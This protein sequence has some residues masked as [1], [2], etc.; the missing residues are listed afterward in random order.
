[1]ASAA[2]AEIALE[3]FGVH[4]TVSLDDPSLLPLVHAILPPGWREPAGPIPDARFALTT[5]KGAGVA[6]T[7]DGLEITAPGGADVAVELL[8][9]KVRLHI[10]QHARN[11]TF[12]HAG[13]VAVEGHAIVLPGSS[14]TGKTT[15]VRALIEQGADYLSDEYAVFDPT[16]LVHPYPKP[17]SIR[18]GDGTRRGIDTSAASLGATTGDRAVPVGLVAATRYVEHAHWAPEPRTPAEG[19]LLLLEHAVAARDD[20]ARVLRDLRAAVADATIVEGERG[21]ASVTASLLLHAR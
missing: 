21:E 19:A 5:V 14:F 10:A 17:L 6:V 1:M 8:D 13:A 15:L 18:P 12:V 9:A 7:Q 11:W 20:P 3:A 16:G 2:L 4:V